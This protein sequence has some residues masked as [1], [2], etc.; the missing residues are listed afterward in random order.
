MP[1]SIRVDLPI[2]WLTHPRRTLENSVFTGFYVDLG[3]FF[4]PRA[5]ID[6]RLPPRVTDGA[7]QWRRLGGSYALICHDLDRRHAGLCAADVLTD[8]G[9]I[10]DN[11]GRQQVPT[12][13]TTTTA[14]TGTGP[15]A[16]ADLG[17]GHAATAQ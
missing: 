6:S 1:S 9:A 10:G 12:R 11:G 16:A 5:S 4:R 15:T 14:E 3:G 7:S 8:N 13:T 17:P 2:D